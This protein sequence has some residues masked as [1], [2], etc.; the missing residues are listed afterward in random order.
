M[1]AVNQN[2]AFMAAHAWKNAMTSE[3][4]TPAHAQITTRGSDARYFTQK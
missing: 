2:L 3:N 1:V 4:G